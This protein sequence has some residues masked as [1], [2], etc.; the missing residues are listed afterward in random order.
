MKV[1]VIGSGGREHALAWKVAQSN[2]VSHVFVAPGNAG[3]A[4]EDSV[5]N[6]SIEATDI[7][8]LVNF[9]IEQNI[10]LTIV[11]SEAPLVLGI[12]DLFRAEGLPIFGPTAKAAQLEGSKSFAKNF[13]KRH[14][15]PTAK[16]DVFED[17]ESAIKYLNYVNIP[18]V[19]KANGLAAGKGVVIAK[20]KEQAIAT[21]RDILCNKCF[22]EAGSCVLIEEFIEGTEASFIVMV[23]GETVIPLASSQDHK[24]LNNEDTGPNTGGM[25]AYSPATIVTSELHKKIINSIILPTIVGMRVE[26]E[27]FTGFLY[28]GLMIS[29]SGD[30]KVLEYNCRLGDPE[31]QPLLMRLQS[32]IASLCLAGTKGKLHEYQT[33]WDTRAA[34]GVVLATKGYPTSYSTG[35]IIE[36]LE[37]AKKITE[38]K[39]FH[40]G[41][42]VFNDHI[43]TNGGRVLCAVALGDTIAQAQ[44]NAYRLVK[45]IH[46][47]NIYYRQD[48]GNKAIH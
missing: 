39:V 31:A 11:G 48:I 3:T 43:I 37:K 6:I 36:G 33:R 44:S 40:A 9:A 12:V 30:V 5:S 27:P 29:N 15:I 20:T 23:D 45:N 47:K 24:S 1:L 22:G 21:V 35:D 19:I 41:T 7:E 34:L 28:A 10:G 16:A 17:M 46:W 38:T 2:L 18:V 26:G 8:K 14:G 4:N 13:M 42:A 32:D 25:G